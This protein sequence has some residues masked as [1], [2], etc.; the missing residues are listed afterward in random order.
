MGYCCFLN[1][2][3]GKPGEILQKLPISQEMKENIAGQVRMLVEFVNM[4][5][6]KFD[7]FQIVV[8]SVFAVLICQYGYGFYIWSKENLNQDNIKTQGFRLAAKLIPQVK[9]HIKKELDKMEADCVKKYSDIRRDVALTTIPNNGLSQGEI[10]KFIKTKADDCTKFY[11]AGG[12]ISGAVYNNDKTHW[13]FL[14]DAMKPVL[15]S[16]PLHI[17]EFYYSNTMEA[18]II[19]W[20]LDLYKGGPETC[21]IVTSG[22]TES[23]ILCMLAYREQAKAERGVTKPNI[24]MSE[25]AHCAFDKAGMYFQIECRRVPLT[26]DFEAD[27]E[28]FKKNIDSNTICLVTSCPEYAF[29]NYDPTEKIAALAQSYGIGCHSD[30]CLGSYVNPFIEELGYKLKY[31]FDFTVPG[32]TSISCDPHKYAYGPKGCSIAMFRSKRLR[33]Y[34]FYCN[35]TWNGGIYA[36]TCIAGSR[37][38]AVIVGTWASMREL[39]RKG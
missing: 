5:L 35:T 4:E 36:T 10:L 26:K 28:Q 9:A 29:G 15:M 6:E 21:G 37:P 39:G 19:R 3:F 8:I 20:T 7:A 1:A 34:Q 30:C 23:I 38:G 31:K 32:V 12:N 11:A 17:N 33:E 27:F 22:G 2:L 18:E 13:E 25:T 14:S 16:N 24:V